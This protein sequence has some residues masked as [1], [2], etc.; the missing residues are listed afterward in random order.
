LK[1]QILAC[2]YVVIALLLLFGSD[3]IVF[4][5]R[6]VIVQVLPGGLQVS[7]YAGTYFERLI[8][9][10]TERKVDRNYGK[11]SPARN[12]P[13]D[14]F[15]AIWKGYIH[16]PSDDTYYFKIQSDDGSRLYID[17]KLIIDNWA[18]HAF[19]PK[20]G[21]KTLKKGKY[22]IKIEYYDKV[23]N[24]RLRLKWNGD[25]NEIRAGS[26]LAVPFISKH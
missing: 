12:V 18:G 23:G 11:E 3:R 13:K 16:V 8:C 20:V 15:S 17:D 26:I 10:R 24:A 5:L 1:R 9:K 7:Y 4:F 25:Q 6:P 2:V 14:H 21:Q 19:L 22:P